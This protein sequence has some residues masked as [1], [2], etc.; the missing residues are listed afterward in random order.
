MIVE[1]RQILFSSEALLEAVRL[2][3]ALPQQQD[4]PFGVI[5]SASVT[6]AGGNPVLNIMVQQS[7]ASQL[8]H[9]ALNG[10]KILAAL[11][12]LC[13]KRQV[14]IPRQARKTVAIEGEGLVLTL[15]CSDYAKNTQLE[16]R[17][18]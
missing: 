4:V 12:L 13:R 17:A 2:Y 18:A 3:S 1:R 16:A 6:S 11:I 8:R 7:G 15:F 5:A 9:V 14:P 10:M